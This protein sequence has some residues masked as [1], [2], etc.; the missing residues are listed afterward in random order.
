MELLINKAKVEAILQVAVGVNEQE[1]NNYIREAQDFDLKPLLCEKFYFQLIENKG[2]SGVFQKALDGGSYEYE[3]A[4]Y[5]TR[6][7]AD[8]LAYFTYARFYRKSNNVSTS[9]G[10]VTKTSPHSQPISTEEKNNM[11]YSYR[12]DAG[13]IYEDVKKFIERN[14]SDYE[15]W[16][17]CSEN[18]KEKKTSN[19]KTKVI[20]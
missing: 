13:T 19:F 16:N 7:F 4:N 17:D 11:F 20:K 3:G 2:D 5:E 8:V 12:K 14:I 6:G 15:S 18:C 1:F 10:F 9:F